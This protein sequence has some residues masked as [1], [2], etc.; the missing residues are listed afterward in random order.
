MQSFNPE[1]KIGQL[2][3]IINTT[4]QKNVHLLGSIV[5]IEAFIE[6]GTIIPEQY[7]TREAKSSTTYK[8]AVV[9]GIH[10]E[11]VLIANHASLNIK[12]L[13]PLPP[14]DDDAIIF[15]NENVKETSKC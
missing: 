5:T 1:L 15:A 7:T 4:Q 2:A 10:T 9:S 11:P 3:M 6:P 12:H 13:M 14:L 8:R